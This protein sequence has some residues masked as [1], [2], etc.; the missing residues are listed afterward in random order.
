MEHRCRKRGYIRR[1]GRQEGL[2]CGRQLFSGP[3]ALLIELL[4][5]VQSVFHLWL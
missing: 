5:W 1:A 2:K 4:V 3:P